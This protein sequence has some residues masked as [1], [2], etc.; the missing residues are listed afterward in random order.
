MTSSQLSYALGQLDAMI[1][2]LYMAIPYGD[3]VRLKL[4]IREL[5][6]MM[7]HVR[8]NIETMRHTPRVEMAWE[9]LEE[10][11]DVIYQAR[12]CMLEAIA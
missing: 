3:S 1:Q 10:A 4:R 2:H 5:S 9:L 7:T 12:L 6:N 11:D 8:T